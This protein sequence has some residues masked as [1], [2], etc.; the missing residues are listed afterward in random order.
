MTDP[1]QIQLIAYLH[2]KPG[3]EKEL[4]S[5]LLAIVPSVL[6]EPGCIQYTAHVSREDPTVVV[7]YEVWADQHSLDVHAEGKNLGALAARFDELLAAPLRL[8]PLQ[9]LN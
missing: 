1:K 3:K 7:M 4:I 8:E 5:A 2:A 9:R 6:E